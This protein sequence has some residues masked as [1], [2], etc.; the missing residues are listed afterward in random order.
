M[1]SNALSTL[2]NTSVA[3]RSD[4]HLNVVPFFRDAKIVF[5]RLIALSTHKNR[6]RLSTELY[7]KTKFFLKNLKASALTPSDKEIKYRVRDNYQILNN[8]LFHKSSEG[9]PLYVVPQW[10]A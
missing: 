3:D 7:N 4:T 2:S 10:K 1:L 9:S 5:Y 8:C 6:F